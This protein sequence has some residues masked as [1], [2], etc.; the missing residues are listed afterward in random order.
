MLEICSIFL[1]VPIAGWA[2]S[3]IGSAKPGIQVQSHEAS[4]SFSLFNSSK[5]NTDS[6][7]LNVGLSSFLNDGQMYFKASSD[8]IGN[9]EPY[10]YY[11]S[12]CVDIDPLPNCNSNDFQFISTYMAADSLGNPLQDCSPGNPTSA[13]LCLTFNKTNGSTRRG[14][15][16]S[17]TIADSDS[18]LYFVNH[19]FD[20]TFTASGIFTLCIPDEVVTFTC[21]SNLSIV[22]AYFAWGS[23]NAA[24]NI[25]IQTAGC[26]DPK[27]D[28]IQGKSVLITPMVGEFS[29]DLICQGSDSITSINFTN[30]T[31]GGSG[32][33]TYTWNFG[34]GVSSTSMNPSHTY[35]DTGTYQIQLIVSD[36]IGLKDTVQKIVVIDQC[37]S[38]C[39]IL[40]ETVLC[41]GDS[42][43][44]S[45]I[46]SSAQYWS[47]TGPN[48][49][50]DSGSFVS[51]YPVDTSYT[52]TYKV[53]IS[54]DY[55]QI[56]SC[57]VYVEVA[58]LSFNAISY[59]G[60]SGD[61]YSI[62]VNGMTYDESNPSGSDTLISF[63]GCDSII[64]IQLSFYPTYI[65]SIIYQGCS[66]DNYEVTVGDT[67]YN[68]SNPNGYIA[69]QSQDGCDSII[70]VD[71]TYYIPVVVEAGALPT[72]LFSGASL[73]LIE[74]GASITGGITTGKWSTS[75]T[76]S[77]DNNA[78]F[79][80]SMP[81]TTYIPSTSDISNKQ[82]ILTLTSDDPP[83]SC[84]PEADPVLIIINDLDCSLFPFTG[85]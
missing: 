40:T 54:N 25:C 73:A 39:T 20:Q 59:S 74:L 24:S 65:D 63:L 44:L 72:A 48:S 21:G 64:D 14:F 41:A 34:D 57:E 53:I 36:S 49:F 71:L 46:G 69:L 58:P 84:L 70:V 47:W 79:G 27:C 83:G 62:N 50:A 82:V 60:C 11:D 3:N 61:G 19:C 78:N 43:N 6:A 2:Q 26:A 32:S 85:N 33:Y 35:A 12:L 18:A 51:I 23:A 16:L 10:L 29:Y 56:D 75:G 31:T 5:I 66:G 76:G 55:G 13:Y 80:G 4:S 37:L 30:Q 22:D 17:T 28:F 9:G 42:L 15:Y 81:A 1:L 52:G 8:S 45:E 38:A 7:T 77:F 67:I 68:E